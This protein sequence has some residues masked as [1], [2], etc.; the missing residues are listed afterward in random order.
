MV[1]MNILKIYNRLSELPVGKRLFSFLVCWN[2][3][4]FGSIS[5]VF[6]ELKPGVAA[7][8]MKNRRKV[9]NHIKTVHAIACCNL[10]ELVAGTAMEASVPR[11]KRWIPK[12]MQVSYLRK[13]ETNLS[14]RCE[15]GVIDDGFSGDL[16]VVVDVKD[17]HSQVVVSAV[18]TMYISDKKAR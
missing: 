14:A 2:A 3:P 7:A 15:P 5:P 8:S 13:A 10:C 17:Q 12:G 6:T 18:I 16:P 9:R 1:T 4:Y 11:H